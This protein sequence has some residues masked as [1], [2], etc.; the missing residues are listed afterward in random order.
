MN[1]RQISVCLP[2]DDGDCHVC[3]GE[4]C[5]CVCQGQLVEHGANVPMLLAAFLED[6]DS[7]S[8]EVCTVRPATLGAYCQGCAVSVARLADDP[9][10]AG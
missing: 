3:Y 1:L 2:C 10:R 9:L 8:C 4:E 5:Q 7:P 6:A